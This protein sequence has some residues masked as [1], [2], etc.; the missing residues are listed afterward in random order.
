MNPRSDRRI[1]RSAQLTPEVMLMRVIRVAEIL[2]GVDDSMPFT[3]TGT[4]SQSRQQAERSLGRKNT[5]D[6]V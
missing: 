6:A 1:K 2:S 5:N 4:V 3:E